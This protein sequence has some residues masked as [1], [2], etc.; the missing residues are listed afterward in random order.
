VWLCGCAIVTPEI[1]WFRAFSPRLQSAL[2]WCAFEDNTRKQRTAYLA[3][4]Q[5]RTE[6]EKRRRRTQEKQERYNS[7]ITD[8]RADVD[9]GN[10]KRY[11]ASSVSVSLG[12]ATFAGL[13]GGKTVHACISSA[14]TFTPL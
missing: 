4:P 3:K 13:P 14:L 2:Q 6:Q 5:Q 10:S 1:V 9:H 8:H 7:A 11:A 12:R